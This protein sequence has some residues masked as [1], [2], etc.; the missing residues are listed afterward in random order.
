M[1]STGRIL[2]VA[3]LAL[4]LA[5][6]TRADTLGYTVLFTGPNIAIQNDSDI[7]DI[8]E[9]SVTIGTN[10][11]SASGARSAEHVRARVARR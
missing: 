3:T 4:F 8:T 11:D 9:F 2:G 7:F 1:P 6:S 10:Y 5:G